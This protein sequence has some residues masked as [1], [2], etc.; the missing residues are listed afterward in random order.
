V[1]LVNLEAGIINSANSTLAIRIQMCI[2]PNFRVLSY[3][4]VLLE[5]CGRHPK[6]PH[7]LIPEVCKYVRLEDEGKLNADGIKVAN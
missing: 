7:A 5:L 4:L 3:T 1:T 2:F 6:D